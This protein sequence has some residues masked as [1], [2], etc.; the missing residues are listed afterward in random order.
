MVRGRLW[1]R[2]AAVGDPVTPIQVGPAA[3]GWEAKKRRIDLVIERGF[4]GEE[5]LW[6]MKGWITVDPGAVIDA[7]KPHGRLKLLD[8]RLLVV[9][10]ESQISFDALQ[11]E[12]SNRFP[13]KVDLEPME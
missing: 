10:L 8:D 7:V 9:E 2:C 1:F 6:R 11:A 4:R 12:L 3:I 13:G 5:L